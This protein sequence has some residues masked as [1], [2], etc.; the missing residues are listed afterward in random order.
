MG[1]PFL[2]AG[3]D[4]MTKI[5]TT[6]RVFT[7]KQLTDLLKKGAR[8]TVTTVAQKA[9]STLKK[10]TQ[11]NLYDVPKL[12]NTSAFSGE[13][14]HRSRYLLG[15]IETDRT[16]AEDDMFFNEVGFSEER[17]REHAEPPSYRETKK[18]TFKVSAFGRYTDLWG[19]FVGDDMLDMEWLEEGTE[20]GKAPRKGAHMI[21]DTLNFLDDYFSSNGI[22]A[23]MEQ[24]FGRGITITRE[25]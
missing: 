16:E 7:E 12:T 1:G 10:Y 23:D 18:G 2:S 20:G 22:I 19:D 3:G 4:F 13:Y 9:A 14:Y 11:K 24:N 17:L 8:G 6:G 15:S 21:A 5:T 25:R